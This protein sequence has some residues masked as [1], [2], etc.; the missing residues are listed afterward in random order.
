MR[1]PV[2][3][4]GPEEAVDSGAQGTAHVALGG[5][6]LVEEADLQGHRSLHPQVQALQLLVGGPVPHMDAGPVEACEGGVGEI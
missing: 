6:G 4:L 5:A 2:A 3:H 1:P